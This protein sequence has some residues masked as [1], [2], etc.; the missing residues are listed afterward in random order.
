MFGRKER[1][2]REAYEFGFRHALRCIARDPSHM[3]DHIE[4]AYQRGYR[5]G[6]Q[7]V[8]G[9]VKAVRADLSRRAAA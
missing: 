2:R 6:Q 9:I 5:D 3:P 1:A 4:V 7:A 8:Q